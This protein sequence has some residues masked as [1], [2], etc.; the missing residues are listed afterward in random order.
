MVRASC[1]L[2]VLSIHK[3]AGKSSLPEWESAILLFEGLPVE[4]TKRRPLPVVLL[5]WRSEY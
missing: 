4:R 5:S 1:F 2:Q 3:N